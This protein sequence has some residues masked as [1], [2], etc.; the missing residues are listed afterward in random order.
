ASAT[1]SFAFSASRAGATFECSLDGSAYATCTTPASYA[2][3]ADG[4]HTFAV[5]ALDADGVDA[6]PASASWTVDTRAP[7]TSLAGGPSG[8]VATA[9]A[10]FA[11]AASESGVS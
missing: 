3:L 10:S 2:S 9:S 5:R 4:P 7:T 8:L 6:T 11:F 1:A